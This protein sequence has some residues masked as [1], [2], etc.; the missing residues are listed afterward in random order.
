MFKEL[1]RNNKKTM[2]NRITIKIAPKG[3]TATSIGQRP[4]YDET[5]S[6]TIK[7]APKG[8]KATSIGQRPMGDETHSITMR[9]EGATA[10]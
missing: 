2:S 9:P 4:M 10:S 7:I 8:H 3:H 6:T 1:E 5:H